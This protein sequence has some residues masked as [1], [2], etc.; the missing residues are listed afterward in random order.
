MRVYRKTHYRKTHIKVNSSFFLRRKIT[1]DTQATLPSELTYLSPPPESLLQPGLGPLLYALRAPNM[2]SY[3]TIP[4]CNCLFT[5][6]SDHYFIAHSLSLG[7][8]SACLWEKFNTI[9]RTD[10]CKKYCYNKE[11]MMLLKR[12]G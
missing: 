10:T 3:H 6:L 1:G 11:K 5:C 7:S 12:K 9:C 8:H 4:N 2:S